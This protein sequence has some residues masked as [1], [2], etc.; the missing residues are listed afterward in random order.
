MVP[1]L[2][3]NNTRLSKCRRPNT[4]SYSRICSTATTPATRTWHSSSM[5]H[6]KTGMSKL[7]AISRSGMCGLV[8]LVSSL[9]TGE[10]D[11]HLRVFHHRV[12]HGPAIRLPVRILEVSGPDSRREGHAAVCARQVCSRRDFAWSS[13]A[14]SGRYRTSEHIKQLK[15]EQALQ[16]A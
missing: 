10:A 9:F 14:K 13:L 2:V 1:S 3:P 6:R 4:S 7:Y 8:R 11:P 16:R 12:G 15:H 5:D